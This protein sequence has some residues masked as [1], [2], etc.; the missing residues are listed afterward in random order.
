DVLLLERDRLGAGTTKGGLGGIRHQFV[1]ELDVRLSQLAT[2]FWREFEEHTGSR[3]DFAERGYLFVAETE[4]GMAQL[5]GPLALYERLGVPVEM[6]DRIRIRELVPGM[7]VDDLRG[8]RFCER[9]GYGDPLAALAGL[10]AA[11]R[12]AGAHLV[13]GAAATALLRE[14]DR[15]IGVRTG[16]SAS[17]LPRR[18]RGAR[19]VA[20]ARAVGPRAGGVA[21]SRVRRS[22]DR[23]RVVLLLRDDAGRPSRGRGG[24]G[25]AWPLP[26]GGLQRA[27][28]H[29]LAR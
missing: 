21:P 6:V 28:L 1:D 11:A 29:A 14:G 23:R 2:A 15:V 9:D 27:R 12:L 10:G 7:R 17:R 16:H 24:A 4:E 26:R 8:G 3:H 20:V 13:E 25:R 19:G 5:R 18:V 22:A